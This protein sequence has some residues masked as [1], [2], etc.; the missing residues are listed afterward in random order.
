MPIDSV[1]DIEQISQVI[2][3][4]VDSYDE[5]NVEVIQKATELCKQISE[6]YNFKLASDDDVPYSNDQIVK[7]VKTTS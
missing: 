7:Y 2:A 3:S 5:I 6:Q 4:I 1:D